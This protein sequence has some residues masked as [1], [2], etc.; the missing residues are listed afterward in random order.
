M[1]VSR[2]IAAWLEGHST[3]DAVRFVMRG[4]R[5]RHLVGPPVSAPAPLL[6]SECNQAGWGEGFD[7]LEQETRAVVLADLAV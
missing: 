6:C 1:Q 2:Y 3:D 5:A 7:D 4:G